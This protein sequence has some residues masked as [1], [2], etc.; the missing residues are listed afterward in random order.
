MRVFTCTDRWE[1]MASCIYDAWEWALIHGHDQL[2]LEKEPLVQ[3]TLFDEYTHV[4]AKQKKARKVAR[5][6]QRKISG[7]AYLAVVYAALCE[8]DLLDHI[9]R[10]LRLG[11][12][13]GKQVTSM[14]TNPYVM[15][16]MQAK[17]AVGNE[18]HYFREFARFDEISYGETRVLV[19]HI[20]P[21]N[22]VL[23][24]VS[25][26]FAD[27][28]PSVDWMMVDD[29]RETAVIHPADEVSYVLE[30][31]EEE[32]KL[33]SMTERTRDEY[34]RLWR[35]FFEATAVRQRENPSCQR[36]HFPLWMRRHATEF[37]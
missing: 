11:F 30:L 34:S 16:L 24:Q 35:A 23:Y 32:R 22:R 8:E 17:R 1:D 9:Y 20:E 5:S 10:F 18:I 6:I 27:R 21:K 33:L 13:V 2:R 15:R 31:S 25:E 36:N 37:R 14:L 3:R 19:S 4:E 12:A 7:E 28:M 29:R 26:H